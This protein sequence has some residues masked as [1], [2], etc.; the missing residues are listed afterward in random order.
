MI[1]FRNEADLFL[2]RYVNFT[3]TQDTGKVIDLID[4]EAEYWFADGTYKG[5]QQIFQAL[6]NT[7][8]HLKFKTYHIFDVEWLYTNAHNACCRYKYQWECEI[9]G[10]LEKGFGRGTN[11]MVH[12]SK[13]WKMLHEHLSG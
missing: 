10:I 3:N 4:D 11:I 6:A 5:K 1:G 7:F 2:R 13:G 8:N 9:N 12:T